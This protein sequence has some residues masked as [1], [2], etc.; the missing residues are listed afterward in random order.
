MAEKLNG[1][2]IHDSA[3]KFMVD[4]NPQGLLDR[5]G[6]PYTFKEFLPT[7]NVLKIDSRYSMDC[8][9]LTE[10]GVILNIEFQSTYPNK[11]KQEVLHEYA[12]LTTAKYDGEVYTYVI[13]IL[14]VKN[15]D[16]CNKLRS[17]IYH[18]VFQKSSLNLDGKELL[19]SINNKIKD[20]RHLTNQDKQD[21]ILIP[22]STK[23]VEECAGLIKQSMITANR[24]ETNNKQEEMEKGQIKYLLIR[25]CEK[26]VKDSKKCNEIR[27]LAKMGN[28]IFDEWKQEGIDEGKIEGKIEGR[29]EGIK[30][31]REGFL[32]ALREVG[33]DNDTIKEII[34]LREEQQTTP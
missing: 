10:E 2:K 26:L 32:S 9:I 7:E 34:K 5:F 30:E 33:I 31:E 29:E 20:N 18:K 27:R 15:E 22:Y 21:L 25:L 19:N 13:T 8:I 6:I 11:A 23:A 12:S 17:N 3:F 1:L 24:I 4:L 16:H 14:P 28:P